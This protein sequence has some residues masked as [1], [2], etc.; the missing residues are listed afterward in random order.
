MRV[1]SR[2]ITAPPII[3][4]PVFTAEPSPIEVRFTVN[5]KFSNVCSCRYPSIKQSLPKFT[6]FQSKHCIGSVMIVRSPIRQPI[7]RRIEFASVVPARKRSG[8]RHH[9]KKQSC[10]KKYAK[11]RHDQNGVE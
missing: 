2:S 3:V 6:A 9:T 1:E 7:K 8:S 10:A 11:W 5:V 4:A